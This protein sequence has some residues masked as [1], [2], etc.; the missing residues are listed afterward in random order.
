MKNNK[1][2]KNIVKY[3]SIKLINIYKSSNKLNI[4]NIINKK[5]KMKK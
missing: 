3:I 4:L 1:K 5:W 2:I